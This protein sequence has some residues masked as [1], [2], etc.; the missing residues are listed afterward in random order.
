ML[1]FQPKPGSVVFCDFKGF[2]MPE[3]IKKRPV[4]IIAKH[5]HSP[6]LVTVVPISTTA[7]HVI[8]QHHIEMEEQFCDLYLRGK[9]SWIK[10]DLVNTVSL[11]RLHLVKDKQS[12]SRHAPHVGTI[13]LNEIKEAVRKYY[14]L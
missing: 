12:G 8:L 10:C 14:N 11:E 3:I 13:R 4:V 7:P 9:K 6:E 1:S 2:I 5:K